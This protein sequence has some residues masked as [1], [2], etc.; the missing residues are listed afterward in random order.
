MVGWITIGGTYINYPVL[1][2]PDRPNYYL[3]RDFYGKYY[4]ASASYRPGSLYA[5]ETYDVHTPSDITVIHGHNM[6]D[7][8]M[9]GSLLYYLQKSFYKSYPSFTF[10]TIYEERTYDII[11]V[12]R[13]SVTP[14]KGFDYYSMVNASNAKEF[15]KFV[16]NCKKLSLYD[17]GVSAE[18]GDKLLLLSTCEYTLENGRFVVVAKLR[19]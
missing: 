8:S 15:N 4:P 19:Q 11:A 5:G 12:F 7:S 9:F 13:T 14:G 6:R 2:S 16:E 18:Y 1:Q 17:T 3:Y 10:D